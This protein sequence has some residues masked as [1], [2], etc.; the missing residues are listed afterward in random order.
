[1]PRTR[2]IEKGHCQPKWQEI[3]RLVRFQRAQETDDNATE[4]ST[5]RTLHTGSEIPGAITSSGEMK[6]RIA[7]CSYLSLDLR[8]ARSF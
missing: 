4:T 8:S 1:M 3:K 5:C 2:G 6:G 7:V